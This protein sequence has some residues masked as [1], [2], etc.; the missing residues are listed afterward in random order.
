ERSVELLTGI[1]GVFK[2]GGA[3]VP[4]ETNSPMERIRAILADSEATVV[5]TVSGAFPDTGELYRNLVPGTSVEHIVYLDRLEQCGHWN[6]V[7]R[8]ERAAWL[9]EQGQR[10][11]LGPD[12]V[13]GT[14]R[15]PF[16]YAEYSERTGRLVQ[17]LQ[18]RFLP[19]PDG[20]SVGV[21]LTEPMDKLIALSALKRVGASFSVVADGKSAS[22]IAKSGTMSLIVTTS[23]YL[24]VADRLLWETEALH[25]YVLLDD[26]DVRVSE[27]QT[28]VK[29]IWE[30][31]AEQTTDAI[32]DYGWTSSFGGRPFS[33]AEM[34]EYI[35][36]FHTKLAPYLTK[37]TKV[38]EIGCGHGLVLFRLAPEVQSYFA[39]DLSGTIVKRNRE[40]AERGGLTHV[41]IR[42]AS[43]VEVG[44]LAEPDFDVVV[45]SSV[46]H[47][48]PNTLYLE[49][50]IRCAVGLLKEEGIIYLDDLLDRSK[51][52]ELAEETLAYRQA[53]PGV[54]VKTSWDE[55]L[56]VDERFFDE[57]QRRF[58]EIIEWE[59]S[60][61]LGVLDN[62][63]TKYRYDV[64]LKVDKKRSRP[65]ARLGHR[66][67]SGHSQKGRYT[68]QDAWG[69]CAPAGEA[70][71]EPEAAEESGEAAGQAGAGSVS[72]LAAILA[73]PGSNPPGTGKPEDL[74]YV[75]YTSG[76][77]GKPKGAMVEQRG[78]L[79][80]LYAK[81]HDF[82][83]T[84]ASVIAQ[85]AS[86]C[87]DISVWQM[88]SAL[89]TGGRVVIYPTE[90]TLDAE[91]FME[92]VL[93]DGITV[94]EVVPSYLSVLLEPGTGNGLERLE[95]LVVTGE[96]VKPAVVSQWF[97]RYPGI[98][99]ANA[100]GPT[101][102]S[103]DITHYVMDRDEGRSSIPV[104]RPVQNMTIYIVDEGGHLCPVGVK[105]EI[106]VAGVG[107]GRGYLHQE[108]KTR[109]AFGEDPFAPER[110]VR[111]YKTGDVG[112][113]LED[114]NIEFL[115]RKDDQVKIRGYRI[116]LGEVENRLAELEGVK[117]SAVI[118]RSRE[119]REA[120]ICAYVTGPGETEGTAI[121][122]RLRKSLPEYMIPEYVVVL[123]KLPLTRN[124]KVDRKA[125]PDPGSGPS[126]DY[127]AP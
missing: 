108:E 10:V 24:D 42:Q 53:N 36:N 69:M 89:V 57:L 91:S 22:A 95:L 92:Q 126:A 90:S 114:G 65:H 101:E 40:R 12:T 2:A 48:F 124:G 97:A 28:Q 106:W 63:L 103:D 23:A 83:I 17:F 70:L 94:L 30:A 27:K 39:T 116:E 98:R 117:D 74:S 15:G 56:F 84:E 77:T 110:G 31:V 122:E 119:G 112:R 58:P 37:T 43:A 71:R 86:H 118:A 109:Q 61:K 123:E 16:P 111:L 66:N 105:G 55:D 62:E 46:V 4:I 120:Y 127:E 21:L 102:A 52:Q 35:D 32:N 13:F 81:I 8:T 1:L 87:F 47:Y 45:L 44:G 41:E 76:S 88:F 75:I 60:R 72:D 51:K 3:Y 96:A 14:E 121:K 78:M 25:G 68:W 29:H 33:P 100:Y 49:E 82:G 80:H 54:P 9:L 64:V 5:L 26:Y 50:V 7:F 99:L 113:W 67:H 115:G 59:S 11:E 34:Q 79:N 18:R 125:L 73:M 85:N 20:S 93:R 107:V 19:L 6:T 104:G 38:F